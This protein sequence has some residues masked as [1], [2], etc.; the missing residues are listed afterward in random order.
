M[1][2]VRDLGVKI[3]ASA[4]RYGRVSAVALPVLLA[5]CSPRETA[6]NAFQTCELVGGN[7]QWRGVNGRPIELSPEYNQRIKETINPI[8]KFLS[9][10]DREQL[11]IQVN[12]CQYGG[13]QAIVE[14][15]HVR[16]RLSDETKGHYGTDFLE[17]LLSFA[18]FAT[19]DKVS[20]TTPSAEAA[21]STPDFPVK[22]RLREQ[23]IEFFQVFNF[24]RYVSSSES[25]GYPHSGYHKDH[26]ASTLTILR[27]YPDELLR[28]I[29]QFP[30]QDRIHYYRYIV[31]CVDALKGHSA[32]KAQDAD[33]P[34]RAG[35]L[36]FLRYQVLLLDSQPTPLPSN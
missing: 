30:R 3:K 36:K 8:V 23:G 34:F 16:L 12:R 7:I 18:M 20:A 26:F 33:L 19:F 22:I 9:S 13:S 25:S 2:R 5:A 17:P 24:A 35:V 29:E 11:R 4:A 10:S 31:A 14:G 1:E 32:E 6:R 21:R 27:Y 28:R 15:I